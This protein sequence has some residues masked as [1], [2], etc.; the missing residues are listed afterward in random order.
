MAHLI[1]YDGVCGLCNRLCRFVLERDAADRF[2]FASLQGSLAAPLLARYGRD[3]RQLDTF[4]VISDY[5]QPGEALRSK[6]R[7]ILFVLQCLGGVW[8]AARIFGALPTAF[9][10]FVYDR[11]ARRRYRWFGRYETCPAPTPA[12]RSKFLD[13][14]NAGA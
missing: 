9:I 11:V 5:G 10:D 12:H 4:Y 13:Q 6:G 14:P 2:R 3:A 7:G 8:G 1:L